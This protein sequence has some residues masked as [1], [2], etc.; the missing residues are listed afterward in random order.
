M[1]STL[2]SQYLTQSKSICLYLMYQNI[3]DSDLLINLNVACGAHAMNN[4]SNVTICGFKMCL[5]TFYSQVRNSMATVVISPPGAK[6]SLI[7]LYFDAT[8]STTTAELER[9]VQCSSHNHYYIARMIIVLKIPYISL[10]LYF[11]TALQIIC[12]TFSRW[13]LK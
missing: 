11:F 10:M 12:T 1:P 4:I 2:A 3:Y 9:Y 13:A 8:E 5:S 6:S 7:S